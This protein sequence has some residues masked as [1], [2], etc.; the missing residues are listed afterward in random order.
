MKLSVTNLSLVFAA[1][2]LA[3]RCRPLGL[4]LAQAGRLC[5]RLRGTFPSSHFMSSWLTR[6]S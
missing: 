5:Y 2:A 1:G 3:S 4:H 6:K